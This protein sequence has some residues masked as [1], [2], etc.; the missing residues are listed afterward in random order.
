VI[1]EKPR[2]LIRCDYV[3]KHTDRW[4]NFPWSSAAPV[5]QRAGQVFDA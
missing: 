4:I 1:Y 3:W 2:S 5:I